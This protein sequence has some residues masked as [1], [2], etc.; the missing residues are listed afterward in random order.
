AIADYLFRDLPYRLS[1]EDVYIT[2]GCRSA[3]EVA[4]TCLS[5]PGANILLP[6]PGFPR[7]EYYASFCHLE[8]RY[9]DLLPEKSW[10]VDLEAVEALADDNTVALVIINPGNPCS[11]VFTYQH[12]QNVA[13]TAKKLTVPAI[14]DEVYGHLAF[15]NNPFLPMG[16]FGSALPVITLRSISKRWTVPGWRLG[17]L[18]TTDFTGSLIQSRDTFS[19]VVLICNLLLMYEGAIPNIIEKT[20]EEFFSRIIDTLKRASEICY[21]RIKEIPCLSCPVK[22]ESSFFMIVKLNLSL[23]EDIADDTDFCLKLAKEESVI[24][25]PALTMGLKNWIRITFGTEIPFLEDGLERI[26]A[27]C[28]RHAKVQLA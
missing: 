2:Q 16:V 10:E 15:G 12:P 6:R 18:V 14:A 25:L 28:V 24:T 27:F 9:Y 4:L 23:L 11:N 13:K 19:N 3:I 1:S 8:T 20:P 21:G 26:K 7:Y 17:W 22:P 5:R